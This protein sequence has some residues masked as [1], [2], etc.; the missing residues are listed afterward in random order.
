MMTAVGRE[1]K[2][3]SKYQRSPTSLNIAVQP[4]RIFIWDLEDTLVIFR[5]LIN[6]SYAQRNGKVYVVVNAEPD[7]SI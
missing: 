5:S 1:N 6:G 3:R 7:I 2:K 4:T